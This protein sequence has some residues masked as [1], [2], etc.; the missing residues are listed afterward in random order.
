MIKLQALTEEELSK[1]VDDSI[2]GSEEY[3]LIQRDRRAKEEIKRIETAVRRVEDYIKSARNRYNDGDHAGFAEAMAGITKSTKTIWNLS[4]NL[5]ELT[6]E[7]NV[8]LPTG[9][10]MSFLMDENKI[11]VERLNKDV[12][13]WKITL[14]ILLPRKKMSAAVPGYADS[15]RVPIHHALEREFPG[16][17]PRYYDCKVDVVVRHLFGEGQKNIDFDNFDYSH[18]LN[19]LAAFFLTDDSPTFYNLHFTG[20][21]S[22][23]ES[24]SEIYIIPHNAFYSV[25][26]GIDE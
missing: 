4:Y 7:K 1:Y 18:L 19:C 13:I 16:K 26:N 3:D 10:K 21:R 14:P 22:E 20:K 5:S 11:K 9:G 15:Y 8:S 2:G 6:G 24:K 25:W 12:D 17:R 23:Q